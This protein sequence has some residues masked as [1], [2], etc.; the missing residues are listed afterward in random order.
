MTQERSGFAGGTLAGVAVGWA[1]MAVFG[2]S[3]PLGP[4]AAGGLVTLV[5]VAAWPRTAAIRAGLLAGSALAFG[6]L[7]AAPGIS[8]P[9]GP[10]SSACTYPDVRPL[11]VLAIG[12]LAVSGY[13]AR[14]QGHPPD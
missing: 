11:A 12:L 7:A 2:L 1:A 6:L 10:F 8:C 3:G 9:A 5:L 13:V 14:R 4:I